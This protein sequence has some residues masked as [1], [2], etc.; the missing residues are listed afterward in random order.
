M[1]VV[2]TSQAAASVG[3]EEAVAASAPPREEVVVAA[4]ATAAPDPMEA[5]VTM[6]WLAAEAMEE[7]WAEGW[8]VAITA[9]AAASAEAVVADISRSLEVER[10]EASEAA[11]EGTAP[12]AEATVVEADTAEAEVDTEAAVA[13]LVVARWAAS[14]AVVVVDT[15]LAAWVAAAWVAAMAAAAASVAAGSVAVAAQPTPGASSET[16]E[17]WFVSEL[18]TGRSGEERATVCVCVIVCK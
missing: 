1:A 5:A 2:D 11:E 8:E 7:G 15:S 14:V 9:E 12:A 13:D 4:A 6:A 18:D 16:A 17:L 3:L 10:L